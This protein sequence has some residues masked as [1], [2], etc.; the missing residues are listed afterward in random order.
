MFF[1]A[2]GAIVGV[3]A[4]VS[5]AVAL[6]IQNGDYSRNDPAFVRVMTFNVQQHLGDPAEPQ[7]PWTASQVGSPLVAINVIIEALDPDVILL[8][9]VGDID[10]G[11][12]Y[13]TALSALLSWRNANLPGFHVW[14]S[15]DGGSIHNGIIS[16]W[17]FV[18]LN[19]DGLATNID[20]PSLSPGTGGDWP[21]GGDGGIRGWTQAEIDLPDANYAGDLYVGCSHFRAGGGFDVQRT[22]AAKNIAAYILYGLNLGSDPLAIFP[23]GTLPPS[24]LDGTTPIIWGGDFNSTDGTTPIQILQWHNPADADD[25]TDRDGG[26]SWRSDDATAFDGTTWTWSSASRL[27]WMYVQDSLAQVDSAFVFDTSRM[28]RDL[29]TLQITQGAP[30]NMVGLFENSRISPIASDHRPVVVD[31]V[32]PD[33]VALAS[34]SINGVSSVNSGGFAQYQGVAHFTDGSQQTVTTQGDWSITGP[35]SMTAT[36]LFTADVVA[37]D[38]VATMTFAYSSGTVSV[39]AEK[40]VAILSQCDRG[41]VNGDGLIDARDIEAFV[42]VILGFESDPSMVC[43]A[44]FDNNQTVDEADAGLLISAL[45]N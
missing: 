25:G 8:Q 41:D 33:P 15:P 2:T 16:R 9:E 35:A 44:N 42:M 29:A 27:D 36:G 38:A 17:P 18:D 40:H 43:R 37:F 34:V 1:R 30:P 31:V 28:P 20:I 45:V 13:S 6:D 5:P 21:P 24:A 39:D 11:T 4:C 14:L 23:P 22:R 7:S 10:A 32:M 19:G 12:S 26:D 3:L